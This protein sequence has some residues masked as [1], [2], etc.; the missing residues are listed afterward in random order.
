[1]Q[2]LVETAEH[3]GHPQPLS[4]AVVASWEQEPSVVRGADVSGEGN[5]HFDVKTSHD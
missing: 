4:P 3:H 5:Q 1:M 2:G